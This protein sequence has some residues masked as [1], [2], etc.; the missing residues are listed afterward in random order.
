MAK[1]TFKGNPLNTKGD[2]PKV[3]SKAPDFVL[4]KTDLSDVS[5]KDFS[6]KKVVLNIF[7]SIDTPVCQTSVRKFN[8]EASKL[9]N[10]VVVCVSVD[11]PFAH[12]RFCG[13]EGI[14]N[15][16]ST[17]ELRNRSFGDTYGV[18]IAEGALA[19]LLSRAVVVIDETGNVKYSE[20][21][22]EI[23]QEPNYV[24]AIGALKN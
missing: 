12:N 3:G 21:V 22:P 1:I 15:V 16:I 23:A 14:K 24:N 19:G 10:T 13:A 4:T 2:L 9:A 7:P 6:G 5:L 20:Q 11:L 17:S 8:E 18:R